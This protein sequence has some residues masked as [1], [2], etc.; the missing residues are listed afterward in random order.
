VI[1]V[2]GTRGTRGVTSSTKYKK[3]RIG[4]HIGV[5]N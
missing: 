5:L 1:H 2:G 3:D 4:I